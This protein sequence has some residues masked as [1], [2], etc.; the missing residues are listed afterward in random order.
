M[1]EVKEAV[2][3]A[4]E[5]LTQSAADFKDDAQE[6]AEK[7]KAAM[8]GFADKAA[9]GFDDVKDKAKEVA[10]KAKD[11]TA[12][13]VKAN[14]KSSVQDVKEEGR[15]VLQEAKAAA[16][17]QKLAS[18]NEVGAA[19]Y[20]ST[21]DSSK[22]LAIG[23]IVCGVIGLLFGGVIAILIGLVGVVLGAKARKTSQTNLATV[24][25]VISAAGVIWNLLQLIL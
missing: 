24:G 6:A 13:D 1:P 3:E 9:D 8:S 5:Q 11:I 18:S 14:F 23:S 12:D 16:T 20:R 19:G 17:G 22:P 2:N 25:F 4:K 10:D 7:A 15:E 21:D